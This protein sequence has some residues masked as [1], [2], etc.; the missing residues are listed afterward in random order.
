MI[1]V[2]SA[3]VVFV[4]NDGRV[5]LGLRSNRVSQPLTWAAI[6][7]FQDEGESPV[8]TA[9][10]EV[11]EELGM[12]IPTRLQYL[13]RVGPNE[14]FVCRVPEPF[15]PVRLNWEN[16]D[17]QWKTLSEWYEYRL[18]PELTQVLRGR[19]FLA[20]EYKPLKTSRSINPF[21]PREAAYEEMK[22]GSS[23]NPTK[24]K[25]YQ[26]YYPDYNPQTGTFRTL[27]GMNIINWGVISSSDLRHLLG[28]PS[29]AVKGFGNM[30]A[31]LPKDR[32]YYNPDWA[33]AFK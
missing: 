4:S 9:Y 25:D 23:M 19:D 7:G 27:P 15:Q 32:D 5:G 22:W 24:P 31:S 8:Q 12:R 29:V 30:S 10:R 26:D 6:G 13:G 17:F 2:K 1:C 20:E 3:S 11:F 33:Q 16:L 28:L 21:S 14:L 18:H